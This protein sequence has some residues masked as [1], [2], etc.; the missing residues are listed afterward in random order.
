ME[1]NGLC[2]VKQ[3][4][5]KL[6]ARDLEVAVT[7]ARMLWLRRNSFVFRG[8]FTPPSQLVISANDSVENFTSKSEPGPEQQFSYATLPTL[9]QTF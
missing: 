7:V 5:E 9:R 3:F 4:M 8:E 1:S 2:I 6:D